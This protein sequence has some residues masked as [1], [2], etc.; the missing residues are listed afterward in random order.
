MIPNQKVVAVT[1]T[2]IKN[3][4]KAKGRA[5]SARPVKKVHN[6]HFCILCKAY[7]GNPWSHDM[8]YCKRH[9]VVAETRKQSGD[10]HMIVEEL[11]ASSKKLSKKLKKLKRSARELT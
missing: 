4:K 5:K 1:T 6:Q 2:P 3:D 8:K 9:K 10:E 11:F 7:G